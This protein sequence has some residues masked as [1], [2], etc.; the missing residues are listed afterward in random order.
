MTVNTA[1]DY[2]ITRLLDFLEVAEHV[3]DPIGR[4][5]ELADDF[6][7]V[8]ILLAL[9]RAPGLVDVAEAF[10]DSLPIGGSHAKHAVRRG[11]LVV[12]LSVPR[13]AVSMSLFSGLSHAIGLVQPG[14]PANILR[15]VGPSQGSNA[16][17]QVEVFEYHP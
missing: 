15:A 11:L 7:I 14:E 6:T 17:L 3:E 9:E 4:R 12:E 1:I 2:S 8:W 10:R 16:L 13:I 5:P